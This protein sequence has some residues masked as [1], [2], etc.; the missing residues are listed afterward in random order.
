MPIPKTVLIAGMT[1]EIIE[2]ETRS[3]VETG[4]IGE[5]HRETQKI[6]LKPDLSPGL[7][8]ST[9]IHEILHAIFYTSGVQLTHAEEERCVAGLES[10][11][12]RWLQ[13]NKI[14]WVREAE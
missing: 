4:A 1:F 13:D 3:M 11:V 14:G 7:K 2:E 5:F 12:F 9:L 10:V 6:Y 8:R